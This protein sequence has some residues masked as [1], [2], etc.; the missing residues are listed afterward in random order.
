[1]RSFTVATLGRFVKQIAVSA[2]ASFGKESVVADVNRV[3]FQNLARIRIK[4]AK[5]LLAE[6]CYDGAYYLAGYSVE[7]ALKSCIAKLTKEH[8]FPD[9]DFVNESWTHDLKRLVKVAGLEKDRERRA[10]ED[11]E[12]ELKWGV[13][14]DW[15]E[16]S[17]YRLAGEKEARQ[18]CEAIVDP[19][20]GVLTWL[21]QHW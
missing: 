4:E 2:F 6:N 16:A 11:K 14:K 1:L 5:A 20:H 13:V 12:F 21:E 17:R 3:D 18:L 7:C 10:R 15:S 9:K 8:D 19:T